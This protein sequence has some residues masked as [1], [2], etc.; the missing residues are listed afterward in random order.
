MNIERKKHDNPKLLF[1]GL[2]SYKNHQYIG[3][4]ADNI[5]ICTY[6]ECQYC[7]EYKYLYSVKD[8]QVIFAWKTCFSGKTRRSHTV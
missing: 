6:C 5:L 3:A 4:T 2:H 7:V 1:S 8:E